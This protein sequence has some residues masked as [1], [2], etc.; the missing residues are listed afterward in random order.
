ME[1]MKN[2]IIQSLETK[3]VLGQLR[4]K[5]R[6]AVFKIVDEQD[7]QFNMGC[8][9]KWENPTLYKILETK[10]GTLLAEV[11]RE[12]M[13]YFRMDYS[14]SI[15]IPECGI[16]PERLKKDEIFGKMGLFNNSPANEQFLSKMQLPLL[17]Y[18][19]Y[20]FI[21][22]LKE[23]PN[24]VIESIQN[25]QDDIEKKSDDII[26]LNIIEF[27]KNNGEEEQRDIPSSNRVDVQNNVNNNNNNNG[28]NNSNNN[29]NKS[30]KNEIENLPLQQKQKKSYE[31]DDIN[32]QRR[33]LSLEDEEEENNNN[34]VNNNNN[35]NSNN[36]NNNNNTDENNNNNIKKKDSLK[37]EE[38]IQEEIN[39]EDID[40]SMQGG[41]GN[42]ASSSQNNNSQTVSQSL[43]YDATVESGQLDN[44]N[45]VEQVEKK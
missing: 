1:D 37:K 40:D 32:Q 22:N 18:I 24:K 36:E 35:I 11:I 38:E 6:S 7:Q 33:G 44:Y 16:S 34:N 9:L 14:L 29:T 3:G 12:F 26:E 13:E 43:G 31:Y 19:M 28:N 23:N 39:I 2:L 30:N 4:A 8:G 21:Q 10:I 20:F 17:Y 45:Y 27:L 15:F 5:L 42:K 25:A 41:S